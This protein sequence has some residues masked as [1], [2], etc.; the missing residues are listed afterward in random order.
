M[1]EALFSPET[2]DYVL[3]ILVQIS[4]VVTNILLFIYSI[5]HIA[6]PIIIVLKSKK[7][8]LNGTIVVSLFFFI[9]GQFSI[10]KVV[11]TLAILDYI[12]EYVNG[13]ANGR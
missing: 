8:D 5:S 10:V 12:V 2:V 13:V 6:L 9:I 4:I 11:L 7:E 3:T 1:S